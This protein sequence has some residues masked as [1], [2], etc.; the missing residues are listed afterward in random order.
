MIENDETQHE[1]SMCVF[2]QCFTALGSLVF[3][4]GVFVKKTKNKTELI[5]I[6]QLKLLIDQSNHL[7]DWLFILSHLWSNN[8]LV[9]T[10]EFHRFFLT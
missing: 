3:N 1:I 4:V 6:L 9:S 10:S 7:Y 2:L 5:N 8:F